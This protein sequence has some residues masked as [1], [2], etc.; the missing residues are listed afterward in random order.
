MQRE[1]WVVL[2]GSALSEGQVGTSVCYPEVGEGGGPRYQSGFGVLLE[3]G[4]LL[5]A[6]H[7]TGFKIFVRV[8]LPQGHIWNWS[9][10]PNLVIFSPIKSGLG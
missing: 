3:Y 8:A 10:S 2:S 4:K 6:L 5:R 1:D 7:C 9:E